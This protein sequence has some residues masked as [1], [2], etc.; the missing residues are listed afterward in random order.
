MTFAIAGLADNLTLA[1]TTRGSIDT[2]GKGV[3]GGRRGQ[4][5]ASVSDT[6]VGMYVIVMCVVWATVA[7]YTVHPVLPANPIEL[8]FEERSPFLQLLTQGWGFFTRDPKSLELQAFV[9]SVDG[10]W[11]PASKR[12]FWPYVP[13]FSRRWKLPGIE[14][15]LLLQELTEPRWQ[16]CREAPAA[17]LGQ[18][19]VS[20]RVGNTVALPR[21]CGQVAIVRQPP[22]PWVWSRAAETIIM[23]SEV[24]RVDVSCED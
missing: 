1:G 14:V 20:A 2:P 6:T 15:G 10:F 19:P 5:T 11:Q 12:R 17:C 23:P 7:A 8:P 18:A 16:Q 3:F 4:P 22:I 13:N 21:N 9:R 24:L